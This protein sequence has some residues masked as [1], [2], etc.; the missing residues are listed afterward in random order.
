MNGRWVAR[1]AG[2][3]AGLLASERER[4]GVCAEVDEVDKRSFQHRVPL[5]PRVLTGA[6]E[7][8]NSKARFFADLAVRKN[9]WPARPR[10]RF[11]FLPLL[12]LL[13]VFLLVY[14]FTSTS[15]FPSSPLSPP[16]LLPARFRPVKQ[17]MTVQP[18]N[19]PADPTSNQP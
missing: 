10:C 13:L 6:L 19:Q 18:T 2:T 7:G 9:F 4:L 11:L 16:T 5:Q 1:P 15:P 3:V 14:P 12:L 8:C 17:P